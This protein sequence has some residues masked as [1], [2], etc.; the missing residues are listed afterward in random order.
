MA[1]TVQMEYLVIYQGRIDPRSDQS[2]LMVEA[3]YRSEE[4]A[5]IRMSRLKETASIDKQSVAFIPYVPGTLRWD[6][7][8]LCARFF[9]QDDQPGKLQFLEDVI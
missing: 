9:N 1:T 6:N 7:Q 5:R 4:K 2:R 3:F 8:G